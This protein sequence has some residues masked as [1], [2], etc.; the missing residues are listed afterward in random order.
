[1]SFFG[2]TVAATTQGLHALIGSAPAFPG[3]GFFV[4]TRNAALLRWCLDHGCASC[5]R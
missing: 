1:V 2:H 4:P 5:S 3:V